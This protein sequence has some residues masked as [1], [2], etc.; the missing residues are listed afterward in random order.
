[1]R[2]KNC[3][4]E[5]IENAKYCNK[6]GEKL[7]FESYNKQRDNKKL[8]IIPAVIISLLMVVILVVV[9]LRNQ[10]LYVTINN[11]DT[12]EITQESSNSNESNQSNQSNEYNVEN[13]KSHTSAND[14][15]TTPQSNVKLRK[16]NVIDQ[17]STSILTDSFKKDYGPHQVLDGYKSTVWAEGVEGPGCG[18]SITLYLDSVHTVK[19]LKIVNGL[20]NSSDGYYKNNRVASMIISFSDG[21]SQIANLSDDN[22]GYQVINL[23][24]IVETSSITLTID[25]VY[26]GYKYDDTC[27][28]EVV[29]LG[30]Y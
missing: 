18:E 1:M 8:I 26:S 10:N 16:I 15:N 5:N 24:Q 4:N 14:N 13:N 20:I 6:C 17:D 29:V 30:Y 7:A 9:V 28:A 11:S 19:Q 2:C 3:G 22:T 23:S 25:S 27:I 12:N 21:T